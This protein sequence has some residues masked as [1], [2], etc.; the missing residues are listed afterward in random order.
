VDGHNDSRDLGGNRG[1]VHRSDCADR[2]QVNADVAFLRRGGGNGDA[3]RTNFLSRGFLRLFVMAEN[4]QGNN[5]Q[6]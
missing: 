2:V 5:Y 6:D 1:G 4:Q 3:G